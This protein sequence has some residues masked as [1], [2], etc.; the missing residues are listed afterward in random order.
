MAISLITE[1]NRTNPATTDWQYLIDKVTRQC[2]GLL[3]IDYTVSGTS[4]TIKQGSRFENNGSYYRVDSNE[5]VS[6]TSDGSFAVTITTSGTI[7]KRSPIFNSTSPYANLYS[8]DVNKGGWY[9]S[10]YPTERILMFVYAESGGIRNV[11]L[12]EKDLKYSRKLISPLSALPSVQLVSII[13]A[14]KASVY[15]QALTI[16]PGLYYIDLYG[17]GGNSAGA[18]EGGRLRTLVD[19]YAEEDVLALVYTASSLFIADKEYI[20]SSGGNTVDTTTYVGQE[21]G[22]IL[23]GT[24]R[25]TSITVTPMP[26]NISVPGYS[27]PYSVRGQGGYSGVNGQYGHGS[28]NNDNSQGGGGVA[29]SSYSSSVASRAYLCKIF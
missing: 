5:I 27:L 10:A 26:S 28:N 24:V 6:F 14:V 13:S 1:P 7:Q 19:I 16:A 23:L 4:L 11:T 3:L 17:A 21:V 2:G 25:G 8:Y 9:L 20:A 29:A 18:G 15:T 22:R 12:A